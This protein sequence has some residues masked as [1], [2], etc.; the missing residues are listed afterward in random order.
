MPS[1]KPAPSPIPTPT[2]F[3]A[4]SGTLQVY[5]T[6]APPREHVTSIMVTVSEVKVHKASTEQEREREQEQSGSGNQTQEQERERE[7]QQTQQGEGEWISIDLSD[8]A[9]T[10]DLLKIKGVEQ[11]LGASVVEAGKY[12]QV[13]LVVN[14]IE[15]ALGGEELK[16]AT[17]PSN[18]LKIVHPFKVVAG[19]ITAMVI[20]FDADKMVTVTGSGKIMVKPVVKLT[21]RQEKPKG[22]KGAEKPQKEI[23]QTIEVSCDD[24]MSQKHISE[25]LEVSTGDLFEVILC[26]NPTTGFQW[27]ESANISDQNVLQQT[28]H[29]FIPPRVSVPGASGEEIW[30]F[31][32][33][34]PGTANVTMDYSRPW[35]GGE[36]GEWT[37]NLAVVVE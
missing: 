30:T 15:V 4:T 19:E 22:Q 16:P 26:S 11:S 36:K 9:T 6:D 3:P 14:K 1:P 31:Q 18:E 27:S 25:D 21:V 17:V 12:T 5:V 10:F 8:N 28:D 35:Q 33:L 2:P 13:R 20:D 34:A 24:F 7:R 23:A 29:K 32:A 37:F